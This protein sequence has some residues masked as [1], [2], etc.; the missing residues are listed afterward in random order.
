MKGWVGRATATSELSGGAEWWSIKQYGDWRIG[1]GKGGGERRYSRVGGGRPGEGK[2][3]LEDRSLRHARRSEEEFVWA[4]LKRTGLEKELG[5]TTR[6]A[7]N[8][9]HARDDYDGG[10]RTKR[11]VCWERNERRETRKQ[12]RIEH[13]GERS[14]ATR[15]GGAA[16]GSGSRREGRRRGGERRD[17]TPA[18]AQVGFCRRWGFPPNVPV[19]EYSTAPGFALH[20]ISRPRNPLCSFRIFVPRRFDYLAFIVRVAVFFASRSI[21]QSLSLSL[22][23]VAYGGRRGLRRAVAAECCRCDGGG[24]GW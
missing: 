7:E 12:G 4:Q 5:I 15:G 21:D 24:L 18:S 13:N 11:G 16:A 1:G 14:V 9:Y 23:F 17:H 6:N 2:E 8:R 10:E 19:A 3:R 20:L 22:S